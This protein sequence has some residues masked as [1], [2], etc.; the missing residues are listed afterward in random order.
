MFAENVERQFQ[1]TINSY[2]TGSNKKHKLIKLFCS[3]KKMT[4]NI[5]VC[6]VYVTD[7]MFQV[8]V[9]MWVNQV[10]IRRTWPW[11]NLGNDHSTSNRQIVVV[12]L[13]MLASIEVTVYLKYIS[14]IVVIV[15]SNELVHTVCTIQFVPHSYILHTYNFWSKWK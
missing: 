13:G 9:Q 14:K 8:H 5:L 12:E 7:R 10:N 15:E 1:F 11:L 3:Y 4:V 2:E 6:S